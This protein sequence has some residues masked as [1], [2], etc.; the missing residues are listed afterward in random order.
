MSEL[1]LRPPVPHKTQEGGLKPPL[2]TKDRSAR[3]DAIDQ[4]R[5]RSRISC[6]MLARSRAYS[7]SEMVPAWWRSSRRKMESLSESRLVF[8]CSLTAAT[9]LTGDATGAIGGVACAVVGAG[10]GAG[11]D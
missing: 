2:H 1:K 7:S 6:S 4:P 3:S 11:L 9:P 5:T 10:A 8:T